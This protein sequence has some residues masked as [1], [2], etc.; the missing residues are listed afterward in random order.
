MKID[1]TNRFYKLISEPELHLR[2]TL[3]CLLYAFMGVAT[4]LTILDRI[5]LNP[6][7]NIF[8]TAGFIFAV[9]FTCGIFVEYQIARNTKEIMK[10]Y[11]IRVIT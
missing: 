2:M 8:L 3:F 7:Y 9:L 4:K 10:K 1:F 6:A 5:A 11:K